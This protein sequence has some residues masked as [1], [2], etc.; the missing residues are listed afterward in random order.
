MLSKSFRLTAADG[1][2]SAVRDGRRAG[3]QQLVLHLGRLPDD[4]GDPGEP[5]ALAGPPT[6]GFVVSKAVGNAVVRNRV[7]RRLR[8]LCAQRL[9][10]LPRGSVLV[11]RALPP[12]AAA[13]ST[14]LGLEL[15]KGLARVTR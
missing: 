13:S 1:F 9:D 8:H 6:V 4:H 11:V 3:G 10:R 12:A 14:T 2:R 7:R 15:D 5:A